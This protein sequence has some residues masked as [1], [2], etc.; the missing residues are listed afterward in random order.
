MQTPLCYKLHAPF[1]LNNSVEIVLQNFSYTE[2]NIVE[3]SITY[4]SEEFFLGCILF[5]IKLS[6][7]RFSSLS[8]SE[9]SQGPLRQIPLR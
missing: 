3:D 2:T 6:C 5:Q 1:L 4:V 7:I 8:G 9:T